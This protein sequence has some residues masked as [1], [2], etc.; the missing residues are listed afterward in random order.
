MPFMPLMDIFSF[1]FRGTPSFSFHMSNTKWTCLGQSIIYIH[2]VYTSLS[3][4]HSTK[5]SLSCTLWRSN[6]IPKHYK[7]PY[8]FKVEEVF[9]QCFPCLS[10]DRLICN[11]RIFFVSAAFIVFTAVVFPICK[12]NSALIHVKSTPLMEVQEL[13][14]AAKYLSSNFF[15]AIPRKL[16]TIRFEW[17]VI[18][19][20]ITTNKQL[21]CRHEMETTLL[22]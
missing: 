1:L 2:P 22:L 20:K 9:F 21:K 11:I 17:P 6:T 8:P 10:M 7:N 13:P 18:I 19:I 15:W 12:E 3:I 5:S 16:W 4:L 14:Y